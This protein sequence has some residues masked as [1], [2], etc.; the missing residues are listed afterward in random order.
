MNT[1][2]AGPCNNEKNKNLLKINSTKIF[3]LLSPA[4]ACCI[5]ALANMPVTITA[6]APKNM[7]SGMHICYNEL[8]KPATSLSY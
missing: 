1:L 8:F 6:N 7:E 3:S 4:F 2:S 5:S